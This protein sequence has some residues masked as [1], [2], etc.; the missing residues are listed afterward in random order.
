MKV[1]REKA[2]EGERESGALVEE[3]EKIAERENR[4]K[5]L[6]IESEGFLYSGRA[7]K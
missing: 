7:V 6:K 1:K 5:G 4:E 3:E 2:R